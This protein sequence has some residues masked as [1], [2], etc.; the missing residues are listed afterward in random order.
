MTSH[1]KLVNKNKFFEVASNNIIFDFMVY[2]YSLGTKVRVYLPKKAQIFL[3]LVEKITILFEYLDFKDIFLKKLSEM[4]RKPNKVHKHKIQ[5]AKNQ[6]LFYNYI[7]N[8]KLVEFKI[9]QNNIQIN[10]ANSFFILSKL[11][12]DV[13]ILF[14]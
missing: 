8:L 10:I 3:F 2:I 7:Y 12:V 4:L 14:I 11:L 6:Q 13:L 9:F 1:V 5:L